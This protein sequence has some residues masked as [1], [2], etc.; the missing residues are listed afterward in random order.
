MAHL[1]E[2]DKFKKQAIR[3]KEEDVRMRKSRNIANIISK[4]RN[5]LCV[6]LLEHG[7]D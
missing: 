6:R 3:L 5:R 2:L 1:L 4:Y 7:T